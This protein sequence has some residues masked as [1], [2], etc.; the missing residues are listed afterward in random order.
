LQVFAT[1]RFCGKEAGWA[2]SK[3]RIPLAGQTESNPVK[4]SQALNIPRGSRRGAKIAEKGQNAFFDTSASYYLAMRCIA[5]SPFPLCVLRALIR[6]KS[7][8]GK[9]KY[10]G[11]SGEVL[12]N[13]EFQYLHSRLNVSECICVALRRLFFEIGVSGQG[14]VV[15][16]PRKRLPS[17]VYW[18][19]S[20]PSHR[21]GR[22]IPPDTGQYRLLPPPKE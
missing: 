5:K 8:S 1:W 2:I 18:T 16:P 20:K 17:I 19:F 12:K 11:I 21:P 10:G 9:L 14:P 15:S 6:E 7:P 3:V 4:P 22:P 13:C